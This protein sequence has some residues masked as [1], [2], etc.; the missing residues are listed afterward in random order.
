MAWKKLKVA[1]NVLEKGVHYQT[2]AYKKGTHNGIDMIGKGYA[3]D[4]EVA[5]ADGKVEEVAYSSTKGNYVGIR[6]ANKYLV[7]YLHIKDNSIQVKVGNKVVK[8]QRV[9]YMG[10]TGY[11]NGKRV[12]THL[13]FAVV[14]TAGNWVDPLPY[15]EGTKSFD[16][17]DEWINGDYVVLYEKYLRESPEVKA[18]NKAR[19]NNLSAA[20]KAKCTKDKLGYAK[21]KVGAKINIKEFKKDSKGNLWGRTN[22]LWVCVLDS[23]GK[24]VQKV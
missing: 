19:Y 10:N 9:G 12:G 1:N 18:N 20:A 7:R 5:I 11:K 21:Y 13:H 3:T 15:L 23:T 8:G 17:Q 22:T 6:M 2:Q 4:W 16:N 14:N 24:Q